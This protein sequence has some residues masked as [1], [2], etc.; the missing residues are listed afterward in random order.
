MSH[1]DTI[2]RRKVSG[3]EDWEVCAWER[4]GDGNDLVVEGGVPRLLKV[5][6]RKGKK[7]WRDVPLQKAV[8][9]RDELEAEGARYEA[10]TGNCGDCYGKGD[11]FAGWSSAAGTEYR[12]CGRCN[13]SGKRPT[14]EVDRAI[15]SG[16]TQ[17]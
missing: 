14:T 1:L 13:G 7:T 16:R 4:I 5:G 3:P 2:G 17:S 11:V 15:G 10:E 8:V 12:T 9:T 6:P